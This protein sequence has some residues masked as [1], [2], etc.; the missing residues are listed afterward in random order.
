MAREAG[1]QYPEF[2]LDGYEDGASKR[3]R[4]LED[5][6][7]QHV[8]TLTRQ[9]GESD[10]EWESRQAET[11]RERDEDREL[12]RQYRAAVAATAGDVDAVIRSVPEAAQRMIDSL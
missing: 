8:G 11:A 5:Q 10:A 6:P 9:I 3:R 2:Y 7:A 12:L 1:G 4:G